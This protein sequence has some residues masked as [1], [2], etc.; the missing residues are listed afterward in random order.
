MSFVFG[1][2]KFYDPRIGWYNLL[3]SEDL[4]YNGFVGNIN[5]NTH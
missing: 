5:W 2:N 3:I 4:K 1:Q